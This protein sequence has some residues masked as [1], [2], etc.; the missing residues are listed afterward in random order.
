MKEAVLFDLDGTLLDTLEDLADSMNAVLR[1]QNLPDHPVDFYR[2]AV[3]D[4]VRKLAERALPADR[5]DG[6]LVEQCVARMRDIYGARWAEKTTPYEGVG[7][8]L[9]ALFARGVACCILS[10]KPDDFTRR[11][12]KA[13]FPGRPFRAVRGAREGV[14]LKPDPSAALEIVSDLGLPPDQWAYVG[15]TNTDMQTARAAGLWAIGALWGF[16]TAEE[17]KA[18]GAQ[19]LAEHPAGLAALILEG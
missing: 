3:G 2:T 18:S 12:V 10:N 15:D 13:F 17:L 16:R 7:P 11:V 8:L 9:D 5:R 19:V 6:P 4:G 14:P 1:E